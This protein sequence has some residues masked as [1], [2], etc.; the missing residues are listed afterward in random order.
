MSDE[1]TR[2]YSN[3]RLT[4][5]W[6][7]ERCIHSARCVQSLPRV[8]NPRRRPWIE[9]DAADAE[10]VAATVRNCPSGALQLVRH[11]PAE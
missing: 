6:H 7:P 8:F 2:E 1:I 11:E 10:A 9:I 3:A 4:I 5:G